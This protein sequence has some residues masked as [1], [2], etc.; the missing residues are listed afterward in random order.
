MGFG[1]RGPGGQGRLGEL[2]GTLLGPQSF[3]HYLYYY[4]SIK[5]EEV[6]SREGLTR[7]TE[8]ERTGLIFPSS[9]SDR[10]CGLLFVR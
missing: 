4:Y 7:A 2:P 6:I 8:L 5:E 1:V 3:Y 10:A 9:V